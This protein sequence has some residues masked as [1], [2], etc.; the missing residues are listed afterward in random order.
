MTTMHG[1]VMLFLAIM[2]VFSGFANWMIPLMI[3]APDMA[4]PRMNNWAFWILP[5]AAILLFSTLFMDGSAPNF[6][7][8]MYEPLSTTY[9]PASTDYLI[10]AIHLMGLSSL[11][12]AINIMVTLLNLRAPGMTLMKMPIFC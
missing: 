4:M 5:V 10:I 3:G 1:L 9:A 11:L 7:W 2:P 8:T 6:G 12:G